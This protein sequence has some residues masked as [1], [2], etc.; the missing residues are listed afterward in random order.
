M[1]SVL[2]RILPKS[3]MS[4]VQTTFR[5]KSYAEI[6]ANEFTPQRDDHDDFETYLNFLA[7]G[8]QIN[9]EAYEFLTATKDMREELEKEKGYSVSDFLNPDSENFGF[10]KPEEVEPI[11]NIFGGKSLAEGFSRAGVSGFDSSLAT[12]AKLSTLRKI[13]PGSY[14]K[15]IGMKRGTIADVL[16]RQKSKASQLGGG[17]AGYGQ[18]DVATDVAQEQFQLGVEGLYKD[19]NEQRASALQ[20]LYSELEN[21]Q[22]LITPM[23]TGG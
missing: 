21:Y 7:Q 1:T 20:D 22:S 9:P 12:P 2:D 8:Y 4:D 15:E 17:F 18:R 23:Q 3:F 14:S 13:D 19:I 16:S 10:Y 6:L 11:K 5:P